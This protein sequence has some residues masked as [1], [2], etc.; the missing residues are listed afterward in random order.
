MGKVVKLFNQEEENQEGLVRHIEELLECAKRG[1]LKNV[2]VAAEMKDENTVITGYYNLDVGEKQY[3]LGH[4]QTDITW[5]IV[6]VNLD[7]E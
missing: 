6:K 3:M 1:E 4:F 5:D 7:L 2:M